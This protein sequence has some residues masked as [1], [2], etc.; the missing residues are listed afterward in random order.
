MAEIHHIAGGNVSVFCRRLKRSNTYYARFKITNRR[1]AN[2]QRY[3]TESLRS[4]SLDVALDRARQRYA[5]IAL[6]E[7]QGRAIK[8]DTVAAEIDK[9][10]TEYAENL[11]QRLSGYSAHMYRGFN[12]TIVRYFKEYVGRKALQDVSYDDLQDY[13]KWRQ[14]Y[15]VR[16]ERAGIRLH[17][18]AKHRAASRTLEWEIGAFKQFLRWAHTRGR[19]DGNALDY[20]F[21]LDEEGRRSAFTLA[22]WT[23]LTSYMRRK[24]WL[25]VGKHKN[26]SRLQRYRRML[27]AYVLFMAN[28]G[29]RVGEAR[30]LS[31]NDCVFANSSRDEDRLVRVA[32]AS[33]HSKVKKRRIVVGTAGAHSALWRLFNERKA[34]KDYAKGGD[35]I[36]CDVDGQPIEHFR[37]GFNTLIRDAGVEFDNEGRKLVIYSLRHT[38][39][40]FRLKKNV[41][42][43]QLAG[44][45]GTSV[46]MIEKYYSDAR[47]TDFERELTK[48]Y[49][50]QRD[51]KDRRRG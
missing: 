51:D 18:N 29:L 9:F 1:A 19:Y 48:G 34:T 10:L 12:K 23:K 42:I 30:N 6:L 2:N 11:R 22:Q 40:T 49:Q 33:S 50:T 13:E 46:A 27:Q 45:C 25:E 37:E 35:Y 39:I 5:E 38:Y 28:T 31:W 15:W 32:V 17:G 24:T 47:S 16:Q 14:S 26:D 20:T 4:S 44:N 43:Y 36:W 8:S 21:K 3:I 41:D 7:K